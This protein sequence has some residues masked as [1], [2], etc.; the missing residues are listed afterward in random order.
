MASNQVAT[1]SGGNPPKV[2]YVL[3]RPVS[4]SNGPSQGPVNGGGGRWAGRVGRTSA[5]LGNGAARTQVPKGM[6]QIFGNARMVTYVWVT[7]MGV[8]FVDEWHRHHILARPARLW[9]T[10]LFFGLLS[11]ATMG[12]AFIPIANAMAFGYLMVLLY[13]YYNGE[14]QFK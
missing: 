11:I 3:V 12:T 14:G 7:A 1:I 13:Q 10:S 2:Q 4:S 9:W 5:V 8:I 6:P